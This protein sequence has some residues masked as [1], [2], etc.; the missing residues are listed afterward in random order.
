[1]CSFAKQAGARNKKCDKSLACHQVTG[2]LKERGIAT[3][4]EIRHGQ[5]I[6][7]SESCSVLPN[8]L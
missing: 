6:R 4:R 7:E 2:C 5:I 8:S 1:M 3:Q